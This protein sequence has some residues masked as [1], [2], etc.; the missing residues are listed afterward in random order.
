MV[1]AREY[2][3]RGPFD[4]VPVVRVS[5][6]TRKARPLDGQGTVP[7]Y[8]GDT[9]SKRIA[10]D[11]VYQSNPL[12][13]REK[14]VLEHLCPDTHLPHPCIVYKS[15]ELHIIRVHNRR[16]MYNEEV[17]PVRRIHP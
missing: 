7:S 1:E 16:G 17:N 2:C 10:I 5:K 6:R 4:V 8:P 14:V 11:S 12:P 13:R 9:R 3:S 15:A